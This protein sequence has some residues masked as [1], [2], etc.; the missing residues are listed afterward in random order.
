MLFA[1]SMQ[2]SLSDWGCVCIAELE[3][4]LSRQQRALD[5]WKANDSVQLESARADIAKHKEQL[6][7]QT[8]SA[9]VASAQCKSAQSELKTA[10]Q[11]LVAQPNSAQL[12]AAQLE[13]AQLREHLRTQ[14]ESTRHELNAVRLAAAQQDDSRQRH[15]TELQ[16]AVQ[17][18][19]RTAAVAKEDV[20]AAEMQVHSLS[21]QLQQSQV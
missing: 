20:A 2:S 13:A 14:A 18:A 9:R 4:R 15:V 5:E 3:E 7:A 16:I 10:K 17:S 12:E 21:C 11:Q 8:E 6:K 1:A 19:E